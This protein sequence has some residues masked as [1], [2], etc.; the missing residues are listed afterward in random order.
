M[1]EEN[2]SRLQDWIKCVCQSHEVGEVD[3]CYEGD[4]IPISAYLVRPAHT[5]TAIIC[6]GKLTNIKF[7]SV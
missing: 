1:S 4:N 5:F 3:W 6:D 7:E 2:I